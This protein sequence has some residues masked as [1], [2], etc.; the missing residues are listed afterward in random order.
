MGA[1]GPTNVVNRLFRHAS[2]AAWR[3]VDEGGSIVVIQRS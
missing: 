1:E 3:I 2:S